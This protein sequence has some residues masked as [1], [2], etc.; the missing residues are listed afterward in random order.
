MKAVEEEGWSMFSSVSGQAHFLT[1]LL[2]WMIM[3]CGAFSIFNNIYINR[4]PRTLTPSIQW[5]DPQVVGPK[6]LL[7]LKRP[8]RLTDIL[9]DILQDADASYPQTANGTSLG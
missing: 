5:G 7:I 1:V 9:T 3:S 4:K 2:Q 8:H 6:L